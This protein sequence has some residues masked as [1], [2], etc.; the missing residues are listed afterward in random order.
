MVCYDCSSTNE[1]GCTTIRLCGQ[2]EVSGEKNVVR[3]VEEFSEQNEHPFLFILNFQTIPRKM[4][5]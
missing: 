4:Y 3:I 5:T 1:D 2:D